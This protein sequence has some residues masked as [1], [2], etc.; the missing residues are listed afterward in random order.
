MNKKMSRYTCTRTRVVCFGPSSLEAYLVARVLTRKRGEMFVL[1][2]RRLSSST[3]FEGSYNTPLRPITP[4][5]PNPQD[6]TKTRRM[7]SSRSR[8]KRESLKAGG[9]E[10]T[11]PRKTDPPESSIAQRTFSNESRSVSPARHVPPL[12]ADRAV[13]AT[14][15]NEKP[16]YFF[17]VDIWVLPQTR[18][19][20]KGGVTSG[21][22]RVA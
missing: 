12:S 17:P 10:Q 3:A 8:Q 6:K 16:H 21:R 11:V 1:S 13:A 19:G 5:R 15:R 4:T 18:S 22:S 2:A 7:Y 9:T 14:V 20:R